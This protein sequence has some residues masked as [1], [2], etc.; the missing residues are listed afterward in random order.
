MARELRVAFVFHASFVVSASML[1]RANVSSNSVEPEN[2]GFEGYQ[3][4]G[5]TEDG[6]LYGGGC[7]N[8]ET[9]RMGAEGAEKE[10]GEMSLT[11]CAKKCKN[12]DGCLEFMHCSGSL[13]AKHGEM[14]FCALAKEHCFVRPNMKHQ[15]KTYRFLPDCDDEVADSSTSDYTCPI[16]VHSDQYKGYFRGLHCTVINGNTLY[17]GTRDKSFKERWMRYY[18]K[19]L[20]CFFAQFIDKHQKGGPCGGLASMFERRKAKWEK[21]CL[22]P[23][24]S[25][26]DVFS[27]MTKEEQQYWYYIKKQMRS[28]QSFTTLLK[29][30][31][32][33]ELACMQ[34]KVVDDNCAAFR[35]PRMMAPSEVD[36]LLK[37]AKKL[38]PIC[39][40]VQHEDA[41]GGPCGYAH[42]GDEVETD[43][44][45]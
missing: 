10:L 32:E 12:T 43:G 4:M 3:L 19:E 23:G 37:K 40:G 24:K 8:W 36:K 6:R 27:L 11:D 17:Q 13:C 1:R 39:R 41:E 25:A 5:T 29:L 34:M 26:N 20:E 7:L 28:T 30:V 38:P 31:G 16:K 44:K 45:P 22:G 15:W 35:S 18:H 9:A 14:N 21:I 2:K 33:K 42:Q